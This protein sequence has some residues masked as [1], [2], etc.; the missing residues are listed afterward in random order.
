MPV[1]HA[2]TIIF[3]FGRSFSASVDPDHQVPEPGKDS[4][5][6]PNS[7][8]RLLT[9]PILVRD[10]G[11]RPDVSERRHPPLDPAEHYLY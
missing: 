3:T 5:Q 11:L 4:R 9:L 6:G 7:R 10:A 1:T 8:L 2:F